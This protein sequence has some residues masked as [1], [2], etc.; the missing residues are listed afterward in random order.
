M[1]TQHD[2]PEGFLVVSRIPDPRNPVRHYDEPYTPEWVSHRYR[3][4]EGEPW[5]LDSRDGVSLDGYDLAHTATG[6]REVVERLGRAAPPIRADLIAIA[7]PSP[8]R[9]SWVPANFQFRG[10]D[11]CHALD[12]EVSVPFFTTRSSSGRFRTLCDSG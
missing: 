12:I 2:F 10:Y 7:V 5:P 8:M 4:V 9:P 3:G 11:Y 6:L 1:T